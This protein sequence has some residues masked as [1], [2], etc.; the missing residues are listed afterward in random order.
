MSEAA[1]TPRLYAARP[2]FKV[3][4]EDAPALGEN[5][6]AMVV[7]ETDAGLRRC[8][9]TF[10]NWGPTDRGIDYLYLDR[11]RLDFGRSMT[12]RAGA[13]DAEAEI[14][15]GRITGLEAVY[16]SVETPQ[17]TALAEDRLQDLR[18]TRRSRTFEDT[19]DR[20]VMERI[21]SDHGLSTRIDV[22]GP[23][24]PVLA[25]LNLSDLAFLRERARAIDAEVWVEGKK[26]FAKSRR[27][28]EHADVT[29]TYGE[30][31]Q[32]FTVLADLANQ[33]SRVTVGGWDVSAK[34]GLRADADDGAISSELNGDESGAAVLRS[35]LGERREQI[36]H[37][38][39][40]N[41]EEAQARAT[42]AFRRMARR[43][44]TGRGVAEGDGRIRVGAR[45]ELK[46][47]GPLFNGSYYVSEARHQFHNERGYQTVFRVERPGLGS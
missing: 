33:R 35:T 39:P 10:S 26:L 45:V 42:A 15:D 1:A 30:R 20:D 47:L 13:D 14:F 5:L 34:D 22:D 6:L 29:L 17:I 40:F 16:P 19:T 25:Q 12:I 44:V 27:N 37:T 36:V 32:E 11:E 31:L 28:R 2:T 4:G 38:A 21:A 23:T 9:A 43:F 3:D 8:E 7:E 41:D 24:Y 18:M 46:G